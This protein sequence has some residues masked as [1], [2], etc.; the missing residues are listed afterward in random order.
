MTLSPRP[1]DVEKYQKGLSREFRW[2]PQQ[3]AGFPYKWEME[4]AAGMVVGDLL[5][6]QY[7]FTA[8]Q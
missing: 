4:T 6:D 2:R 5:R 1:P 8:R 3:I 7:R